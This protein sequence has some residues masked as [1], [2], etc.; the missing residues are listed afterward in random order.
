MRAPANSDHFLFTET[1]LK[2]CPECSRALNI[3]KTKS[4]KGIFLDFGEVWFKQKF[5]YCVHCECVFN[6]EELS[7]LVP[8][9]ANFGFD[10][11]EFIGRELFV[12]NQTESTIVELLK[13]KNVAIS[14]NEVSYLGK[15][16]ILY[17][18]QA[19]REKEPEIKHLINLRGGYFIHLDSTCDGDSPHL[20]CAI[21]ELLRLVLVARKIPSESCESIVPILE[22]LKKAYGNPVGIICDMSKGI[23]AAIQ[24]IFPEVRVFICHFHWL[25]DIG[26]D[27]LKEDDSFL[28]SVLRDFEVKATLSKFSR[29]FRTLIKN[30]SSLSEYLA[31]DIEDF[32]KQKLPEEVI[33]HLL[34]EWIQD[35]TDGL[36]GYGFP[37]DRANVSLVERMIQV[38]EH[39]QKLNMQE[40]GRLKKIQE[41]LQGVLNCRD[42]QD[43]LC[44]LKRR[45]LYFER[46]RDIMKIAP[47]EGADGLNDD[48]E[49]GDMSVMEKELKDFTE[50][51]DIKKAAE[52][53]RCVRKMLTQIKKYKDR[54]FTDGIEVIDASG[55]KVLIHCE[56]TNNI[57]E[58]AFRDEKR[59]H[60]KRTGN[61]SMSQILKTML[62]ETP[63]VKNL[64][65][66]DYLKI[67][68]NGKN[69]L[70]ERF[71]EIDG[72]KVRE[73]MRKHH[74]K[75][76]RLDPKVKKV[77]K[78]N[79]LLQ[80][81]VETIFW[82]DS[83]ESIVLAK[84]EKPAE[85]GLTAGPVC[86]EV[87]AKVSDE[88]QNESDGDSQSARLPFLVG[89]AGEGT[90]VA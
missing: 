58:R 19:H 36:D 63:Y 56:R 64:A 84:N 80:N 68:L 39:L 82:R 23:L 71:A 29:E 38:H 5:K 10:I 40:G 27:L 31:I 13:T 88:K 76:E 47:S 55:N 74:E 85:Q 22:E 43:C 51:E 52:T 14:P 35:Y 77:I 12:K 70:A 15:K 57:A 9:Y 34:I 46:L 90:K 72:S 60:R 81:I 83:G 8:E 75:L 42:L 86:E 11:I 59:G 67:I 69:T 44:D 18:A 79:G 33:A 49:D 41:F 3:Q 54:L 61:K 24:E 28:G 1:N 17:L 16:F 2:I 30:T 26:K 73:A 20:F 6:S 89:T 62:A 78:T 65:N 25:R 53:D 48:G 37:F 45:I 21:E 4:R 87:V 32:F 66:A 50:R 7:S